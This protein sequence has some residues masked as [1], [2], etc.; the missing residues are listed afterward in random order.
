MGSGSDFLALPYRFGAARPQSLYKGHGGLVC[1]GTYLCVHVRRAGNNI[2]DYGRVRRHWG[3]CGACAERLADRGRG[4]PEERPEGAQTYSAGTK[5]FL[6]QPRQHADYR[7]AQNERAIIGIY[8]A[9]PWNSA[10]FKEKTSINS[11]HKSHSKTLQ[12]ISFSL[13]LRTHTKKTGQ[14]VERC[15]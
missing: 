10:I 15:S 8:R 3:M 9:N 12:N 1:A 13:L 5:H 14:N 7:Y 11:I 2:Y 6:S 4:W